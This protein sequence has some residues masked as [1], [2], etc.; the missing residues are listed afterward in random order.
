MIKK[1][2]DRIWDCYILWY[3]IFQIRSLLIYVA[4]ETLPHN[5][6]K[7]FFIIWSWQAFSLLGSTLVQFA[8]IWWITI[9]TKSPLSLSIA[10]IVGMLP[11]ALIWPFAGVWVDRW[12]RRKILIA[13]DWITALAWAV[14]AVLYY[15]W[16]IEVWHVYIVLGIRSVCGAF[17]YPAMQSSLTLIVPQDKLT[18]VAGYNQMLFSVSSILGP[19]LGALAF[20]MM[21]MESIIMI[22][23]AGAVLAWVAL[24]LVHIPRPPKVESEN[25]WWSMMEEMRFWFRTLIKHKW[26]FALTI[27]FS[28]FVFIYMPVGSLY[29]LMTLEYFK[30]W[31]MQS[32]IVEI[33]F[34]VWMFLWSFLL[35]A[36]GFIKKKMLI[37][38][39]A[40]LLMGITLV[41]MG[42]LP[43]NGYI[44]FVVLSLIS[45]MGMPL[46]NWP[47]MVFV[48]TLIE[49]GVQGRVMSLMNVFI[50]IATPVGLIASWRG[51]A[52][53]WLSFWFLVCGALILLLG[54]ACFF[55][56]SMMHM[57]DEKDGISEN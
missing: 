29:P 34:G 46:F 12:D 45:G 5:R 56:P 39:S 52:K 27:V 4:M 14:L 55:I 22:D 13:S 49:P 15:L 44:L 24:L 48:Q 16:T 57:E 21:S 33:A 35:S 18:R 38:N 43:P 32:S 17:Q 9:T 41:L 36:L 30:G 7:R 28:I 19:A 6:K 2:N 54:I 53:T 20:S 31:A 8:L 51:A 50:M 42:F 40:I 37:V 1:V 11:A 25:S 47:F 3:T 10:A 23:V 26:L